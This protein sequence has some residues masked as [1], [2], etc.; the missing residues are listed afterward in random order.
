[1]LQRLPSFLM[2][3]NSIRLGDFGIFRLSFRA[4]GQDKAE[5]VSVSDIKNVRVLFLARVELKHKISAAT[6]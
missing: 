4:K 3:G 2:N 5:D 6:D 1:M